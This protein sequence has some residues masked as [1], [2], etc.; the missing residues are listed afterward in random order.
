M[1]IDGNL[2]VSIGT[3]PAIMQHLPLRFVNDCIV[4]VRFIMIWRTCKMTYIFF[5][6]D[7]LFC[8]SSW[9]MTTVYVRTRNYPECHEAR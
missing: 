5:N 9:G 6:G 3:H 2:M 1:E 7:L 4:L 8:H